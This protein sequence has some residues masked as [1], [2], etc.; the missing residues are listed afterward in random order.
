MRDTVEEMESA[1]VAFVPKQAEDVAGIAPWAESSV[2]TDRMWTALETGVKGGKWF[3]LIDKVWKESNLRN[4][5]EKVRKNKGCAGVDHVGV[6]AFGHGL[7][8][9]LSKVSQALKAG[10]YQPQPL[11]RTYI[12]KDGGKGRRALSI[13]TVR[14]RV[15]HTAVRHVIEPIF[16]QTFFES[17]YG[18]RP[19]KSSKDALR[20]VAELL[21]NGWTCVVDADL[22]RCF[23]T[24]PHEGL[25]R[26]LKEQVADSRV[27]KLIERFLKQGIMEAGEYWEPEE[28][29]PQGGPLSPLLA[30][31]YL[32]PLDWM[33]YESGMRMVRYADD[34]VVLCRTP[35]QAQRA[36]MLLEQWV[37]AN[38]LSLHPLK[39]R[40]VDMTGIRASFDFLGYRFYRSPS[41]RL[42]WF[43]KPK[44]MQKL[45][46]KLRPYTKRCNGHSLES[47][48]ETVN[49]ILRGWYGYYRHSNQMTFQEVDRWLRMR[50]RSILRK[51]HHGR[52]RGRGRDHQRWPNAYFRELGLF[53]LV[54]ARAS[55]CSSA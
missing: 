19:G 4:S 38:G 12:D 42:T 16:E 7:D 35:Q 48:I 51:R 49:P 44:S 52:G 34:L 23:D 45:R 8:A 47:I 46:G 27:L 32:S 55:L 28:G 9:E 43:P 24:I 50:L 2:W 6:E 31:I 10:T 53:S 14:D 1:Q 18:F 3:S 37:Q 17:S 33:M 30:N 20:E 36:L 15:V 13:P 54:T 41:K 26:R 22:R 40:T 11:K 5:Y 39:T 25:L 29:T 21:R